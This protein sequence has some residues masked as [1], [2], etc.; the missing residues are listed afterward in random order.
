ME[1]IEFWKRVP[2]RVS[3]ER[4]NQGNIKSYLAGRFGLVEYVRIQLMDDGNTIANKYYD[5]S[6]MT[7]SRLIEQGKYDARKAMEVI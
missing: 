2:R 7:I 6:Q 5:Y 3:L 1:L 4:G